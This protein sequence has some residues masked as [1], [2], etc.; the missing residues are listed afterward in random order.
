MIL[1]KV[2]TA[3]LS[4]DAKYKIYLEE[5]T[6]IIDKQFL[7]SLISLFRA[8]QDIGMVGAIGAKQ[9]PE[10]FNW[11]GSRNPSQRDNSEN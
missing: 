3:M 11:V 10:T 8:N 4:S 6:S 9:I 2:L 5:S 1:Q 7:Y